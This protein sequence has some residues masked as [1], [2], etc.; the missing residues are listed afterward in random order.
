[1]LPLLLALLIQAPAPQDP[2][3]GKPEAIYDESA[4]GAAQIAAALA[5]AKK[6]NRRVL[7]Q[8]GAN[9]CGWCRTLHNLCR[10]DE[11]IRKELLYEYDV[12]L[13][14]IGRHDKHVDLLNR[15]GVDLTK[16]G[17]PYLTI[18]D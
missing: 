11:A 6:E 9:W 18:L 16:T 4:D 12:V 1:M 7:V 2:P 3:K 17:V 13:V 10:N 5:R 14:D 8:W 15:Y